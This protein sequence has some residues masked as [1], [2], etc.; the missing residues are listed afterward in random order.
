MLDLSTEGCQAAPSF[1]FR[2]V[3]D[4]CLSINT[5]VVKPDIINLNPTDSDGEKLRLLLDFLLN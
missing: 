4:L 5:G 1:F 2:K 3:F